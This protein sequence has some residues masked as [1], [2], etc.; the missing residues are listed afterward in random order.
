MG[1][2][3]NYEKIFEQLPPSVLEALKAAIRLIVLHPNLKKGAELRL[4]YLDFPEGMKRMDIMEALSVLK[5]LKIIKIVEGFEPSYQNAGVIISV[6]K[7]DELSKIKSLLSTTPVLPTLGNVL[8]LFLNKN[9]ELY[10][11]PK[12]QFNYALGEDSD[13]MKILTILA[14]R[15][16]YTKTSQLSDLLNGKSEPSIRTEI[17]KIRGNIKKFLKVEGIFVIDEG[18]KGSGYRLH[19]NCRVTLVG[20]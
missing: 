6:N 19:P 18:K 17:R 11:E 3:E 20:L 8:N 12:S 4:N 14:K 10:K 13:R 1:K 15:V 16:G 2:K 7:V 9:G 5:K